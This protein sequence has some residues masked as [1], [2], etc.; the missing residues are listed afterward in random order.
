MAQQCVSASD[1][2]F[3]FPAL[4]TSAPPITMSI[5]FKVASIV[6]GKHTA[7][8]CWRGS[9]NTEFFLRSSGSTWQLRYS[10]AGGS[11]W[12]ITTGLNVSTG[13]WQHAC[14]A[15]TSS[16]ARLYLDGTVFTANV[17]HGSTSVDDTGYLAKDPFEDGA[18]VSFNGA[19]GEAAIWNA[20]LTSE[21]CQALAKRVSPLALAQRIPNLVL[22]RDLMRET[23]RGI[24]PALTA[25]N[26]PT[27]AA[28]P[29]VVHR[30]GK[31]HIGVRPAHFVAP[32]LP[33]RGITHTSRV[34]R[35]AAE[36]AGVSAGTI[37][38][39]GEVSS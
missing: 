33:A 35:A 19:I 37:A 18:R 31:T 39:Y 3:T 24:G 6:V 15:I 17:S 16:Q 38:S 21:E 7:M 13:I 1:Q 20:A 2:Y 28:H 34:A 23:T 12:N 14:V 5:W 36:T 10:I 9:I 8:F 27:V 22:Y 29:P 26:S 4:G 32:Y 25:V 30:L 11:Q